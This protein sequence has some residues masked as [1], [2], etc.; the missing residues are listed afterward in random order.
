MSFYIPHT[1]HFTYY[2]YC[3]TILGI[4][5]GRIYMDGWRASGV[6]PIDAPTILPRRS[7]A[8]RRARYRNICSTS[9]FKVTNVVRSSTHFIRKGHL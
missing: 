5:T 3:I 6:T 1:A 9:G 2:Q 8:R 7:L 4:V